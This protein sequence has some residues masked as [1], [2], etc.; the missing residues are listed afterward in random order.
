MGYFNPVEFFSK[1]YL[2][3]STDV[4]MEAAPTILNA[5]L[6]KAQTA[7]TNEQALKMR[8]TRNLYNK[9]LGGQGE[10]LP[11]GTQVNDLLKNPLIR[12]RLSLP[13]MEYDTFNV[14]NQDGTARRVSVPK[15]T[16]YSLGQG[17]SFAK[18]ANTQ[19]KTREYVKDGIT[20][21]Q[22]YDY[23]PVL[24]KETLVGEPYVKQEKKPALHKWYAAD[25]TPFEDYFTE[26]EWTGAQNTIR[27]SGG[28]LDKPEL[29]PQK[30][31]ERINKLLAD[32]SSIFKSRISIRKSNT[33]DAVATLLGQQ[34]GLQ[35]PAAGEPVDPGLLGD[36]DAALN[37]A[38]ANIDAELG[39]LGH[40]VEDGTGTGSSN[41]GSDVNDYIKRKLSG[42]K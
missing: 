11:E 1:A 13:Q 6:N 31:Q 20:Y 37:M 5:P 30:K 12:E 26:D 21:S 32:R 23:D 7:L 16:N 40:K 41:D 17:E 42:Q 19:R 38:L 35:A 2:R 3:P 33:L 29:T 22:D 25:G 18:A 9:L 28:S 27:A 39:R 34:N 15:G 14:Y 36:Y 8:D 10:A 24:T 4:L